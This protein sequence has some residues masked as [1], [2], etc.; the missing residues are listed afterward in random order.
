MEK[1]IRRKSEEGKALNVKAIIAVMIFS[2]FLASFNETILNVALSSL[3]KE[4][5]IT[6]GTVQWIVTAYMIVVAVFVPVTAFLI[7][8][9]KTKRLFLTSM[10][11]LL[12]GT[13]LAA[14][15]GSFALLLSARMIQA[16][17]TGMIIPIMMN[18][19]L[20]VAPEGKR[21]LVMGMCGASLTVGPAFG[22][23][24]AGIVLQYFHW[25]VLFYILIPIIVI[26]VIAGEAV[27][28]T[29]SEIR[30]PK[31]DVLSILLSTIA[32]GGLIFG[33]SSAS[34]EGSRLAVLA[35]FFVGLLS[36]AAFG[37]RQLSL[38]EPMLNIKVFRY[39]VFTIGIIL[40]MLS[41]M[42][43]FTM[44]VMLPLYFEQGMGK[45]AFV[46]AMAMLPATLASAAATPIAGKILD[47]SGPCILLPTGFLVI[48]IP[49][50]LIA[51]SSGNT[52]LPVIIVLFII[53][54]VGVA[55][56]MSP[57]QT[58]TL[59]A[60]PRDVYPHGVAIM[61][62][63]QQLSAAIGSALFIGIM[64]SV[65]LRQVKIG[66]SAHHAASEGFGKA[67]LVL[68]IFVLAG[69]IL[70][71]VLSLMSKASEVADKSEGEFAEMAE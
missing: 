14:C 11:I 52:A 15:S 68:S 66:I 7:Q 31:M 57:S 6:A 17:G 50:F 28:V 64:S 4:M 32:F 33:I 48:L 34:G 46:A 40:V 69:V 59:T 1:L 19:V 44:A 51:Y 9:F 70:S 24:V 45:S 42:A 27:M 54:D 49:L 41:M 29:T 36:L 61:N 56:T 47:K 67:V 30:K 63:L 23:T 2:G 21:G 13:V 18:T 62:T 8:T 26:A 10:L 60:L 16:A 43:I 55:L 37:K 25:H 65:Q 35:A 22:P 3:M 38:K 12:A 58:T 39:P 5:D 71:V 53:I 20:N